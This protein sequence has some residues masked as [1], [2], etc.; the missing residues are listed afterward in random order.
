MF[1]HPP[2]LSLAVSL[3]PFFVT[4][5]SMLAL[6][7]ASQVLAG[8]TDPVTVTDPPQ[9][10][11]NIFSPG[12]RLV[13][14]LPKEYIEEEFFVSGAATLFN[15]AHNPPLGP[16]DLV[17]IQEDVPYSTRIIVRRPVNAKKFNGTVVVEWWNSTAGFDTA[18]GWD[19]SAEYFA[20]E[21][22]IYVGVTN[23]TTSIGF[24]T[25]GCSLLG[26]LPPTCGTRYATL[27]LPE[28]GLAFDAVNQI[29]NLLKSD[30]PNNP[31][32]A[33]YAVER[34]FH[35]GESQQAGSV[36]TYASGFHLDGV[37]DGYFIQSG[38]NARPVN[39]G[40]ACGAEG[41]PPYPDCTPRLVYP[42]NLVST[43]LPVPVY[44]VV[45]QT[46]FEVLFGGVGRQN[47]AANY[48]Y[49][50]VAGGAH[51]TVHMNIEIIP[52]GLVGPNPIFLED[53]CQNTI[54][55]TA[56]GPVFVS[57]VFN[58]LWQRMAEQVDDGDVPP[59]GVL[60]D[61]T[62]GVLNLDANGNAIG[63]VRLPSMEA[64][65]ATYLPSNTADPSLPPFL[66]NIGNLACFLSGSVL[67]FD[68]A[69]LDTLYPNHESYVG[70]VVQSTNALK[71]QGLLLQQDASILKK[72]AS[73]SSVGKQ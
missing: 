10:Q 34:L 32:P 58:A 21:G 45:T 51:S 63:G 3:P 67:P 61:D 15:Y 38:A 68:E 31:I 17:P 14:N 5:L 53:L 37:N 13:E 52:A 60:M 25:G 57:Y 2:R 22:G 48:R 54:N 29:A 19:P 42:D 46:D 50:E 43:D 35:V 41:S 72:A 47:D 69:T 6:L 26:V 64:P 16:T 7:F 11:G 40:P 28:N 33:D 8:P 20:S 56:D 44:Q 73:M 12:T 49:Y 36:I 65:V 9:G 66:Q 70:A 27:S 59:P 23:S 30:E 18:P 55:T 24:L 39:F 1:I 4:I 62:G 71:S